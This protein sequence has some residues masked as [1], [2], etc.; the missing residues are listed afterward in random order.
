MSSVTKTINAQGDEV[1]Y[2]YGNRYVDEGRNDKRKVSSRNPRR[3]GQKKAGWQVAE[4]WEKHHEIARR[5]VLGIES[6]KEIAEA[7]KCTPQLVSMVRNSP[8]VK[9]KVIVMRAARDADTIDLSKDILEMAPIAIQRMREALEEGRVQG[10][11]L[12][13]EGI[14]KQANN[15]IDREVGKPTQRVDTRNI[16]GHF[17]L[18]DIDR[19]KARARELAGTS[20]IMEAGESL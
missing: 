5:L 12:S 8:V 2:D 10:K 19:I 16:H 7:L 20:G 14:L 17:T 15:I 18:D 4:M 6:N 13:A 3:Q 1:H 9:D 11:E